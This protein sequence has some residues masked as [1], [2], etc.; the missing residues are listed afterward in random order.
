MNQDTAN[1]K[2]LNQENMTQTE[3]RIIEE[4]EAGREDFVQ[5]FRKLVGS[6]HPAGLDRG[7]IGADT[8]LSDE[9]RPKG[10]GEIV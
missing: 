4:V 8:Y 6:I 3:K 2:F 9:K 7:V 10:S 1:Q 5:F